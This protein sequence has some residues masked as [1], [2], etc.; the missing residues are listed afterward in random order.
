M[1]RIRRGCQILRANNGRRYGAGYELISANIASG[2]LWATDATLVRRN[3]CVWSAYLWAFG[4]A[5]HIGAIGCGVDGDA[6][7]KQGMRLGRAAVVLQRTEIELR[8]GH[9]REAG[10]RPVGGEVDSCGV[11]RP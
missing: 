9:H 11:E 6:S 2:A 10:T 7:W 8:R 4:I 1:S 3:R 5:K